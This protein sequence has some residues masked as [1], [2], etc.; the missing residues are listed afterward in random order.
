MRVEM[1]I[2]RIIDGLLPVRLAQYG[3][4]TDD[5][6]LRPGDKMCTEIHQ[7]GVLRETYSHRIREVCSQLA[8]IREVCLIHLADVGDDQNV[9]PTCLLL[10]VCEQLG[11]LLEKDSI[12][13]SSAALHQN[14][15]LQ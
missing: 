12:V 10:T 9:G 11:Q 15:I 7:E 6:D 13:V 14:R 5:V 2:V 4:R 3:Q 1:F 8:H